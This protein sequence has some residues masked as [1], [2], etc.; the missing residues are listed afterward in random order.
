MVAKRGVIDALEYSQICLTPQMLCHN[1]S[2]R[3]QER[4]PTSPINEPKDEFQRIIGSDNPET[5]KIRFPLLVGENRFKT[6]T[7]YLS[8]ELFTYPELRKILKEKYF[9]R[10]VISSNPTESGSKDI[11]LYHPYFPIKRLKDKPIQTL[12]R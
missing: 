7:K 9:K 10:L 4:K 3:G 6:I 1:M 5:D 12:K 8:Y 11:D 2:K